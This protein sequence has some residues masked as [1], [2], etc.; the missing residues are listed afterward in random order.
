MSERNTHMELEL[1]NSALAGDRDVF[2]AAGTAAMF[3]F[4][5]HRASDLIRVNPP[6]RRGLCEIPRL[7]IGLCGVGA[8]LLAPRQALIDPVGVRLVGDNED[9]A[10]GQAAVPAKRKAP[11]K[12]AE[13]DRIIAPLKEG[14]RLLTTIG[15]KCKRLTLVARDVGG[16]V[17]Q[18]GFSE[19][20]GSV[21][22][23]TLGRAAPWCF[24]ERSPRHLWHL[25]RDY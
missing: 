10:V 25:P 7:A 22:P 18:A 17:A 19:A 6:I 23:L 13:M 9:A 5:G 4:L 1:G 3:V 14:G 24:H 16:L 11:A 21:I 8:A 15:A 2:T 20:H 12:M